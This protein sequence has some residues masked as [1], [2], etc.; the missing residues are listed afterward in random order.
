LE[1][2]AGNRVLAEAP[3]VRRVT[4]RE[5]MRPFD[6]ESVFL[7][8]LFSEIAQRGRRLLW[9]GQSSAAPAGTIGALAAKLMSSRGEASGV[10]L[11][12]ELLKAWR[13]LD[14]G[15]RL[16]WFRTLADRFGP[17]E[18]RLDAAVEAW[19]GTRSAEAASHLASAAEPLRQE[20]FR[21]INLAPGGTATLVA[22]RAG[23]LR[24][25]ADHPELEVVDRDF[26]HL[27]GSWFNR[28]F[29]L[30][31]RIDWSSPAHILEKIIRYEAVHEIH[32]WDDLRR[33]LQPADRRCFAFVH[34]QMPDEPLIFVEVALTT[35]IPGRIDGLLARDREPI[36]P[37]AADTAVFYSISNTQ[38][39]L[40][41][42][43]FGSFLI[44]QV[45]EDIVR[46]LP[47]L[48]SFVTLSPLPGFADWLGERFRE[49]AYDRDGPLHLLERPD[50]SEDA[51]ARDAIEPV[52]AAAVAVYLAETKD[53]A[54]RPL[55]PVARFHLGNGARLERIN[56]HADLS[57]K[58]LTQS[59]GVMVNYLYDL[60]SI[61]AHHEAYA[62]K[63]EVA[64][65][66][67]VRKLL[68]AER[69]VGNGHRVTAPP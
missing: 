4:G 27:F 31:T 2:G 46:D 59:H 5:A 62:N 52:L 48:R 35:G 44:K 43:S 61:E 16:E 41:G 63:G 65:S 51:A 6:R 25:L 38:R 18:K 40:R 57:P 33:R 45:V 26:V 53:A 3:A 1:R 66:R 68:S 17:D 42:I 28:G 32:D 69:P 24:H 22:M 19:R 12:M 29:L 56:V 39:G 36:D 50:W 10:A 11:A 23:L 37:G 58:G 30:M 55:D 8:E 49:E 14:D 21:R 13:Q 54:G 60:S 67:A 15:A 20:L 7:G 9:G 34:P 47:N 64:M